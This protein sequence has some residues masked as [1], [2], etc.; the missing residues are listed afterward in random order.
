MP[1]ADDLFTE[2]AI[3]EANK[4]FF[5]DKYANSRDGD[6]IEIPKGLTNEDLEE[7]T[8]KVRKF[9]TG[10][11]R[12]TDKDK[13]DYEG[14][15]SPIVLKRYAEYLHKHR[16]QADGSYR[17]SDNWQKGIPLNVYMK[18]MFRHFMDVWHFHRLPLHDLNQEEALCAV[19]FNTIGYLFE[20]LKEKN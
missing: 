8:S 4:N 13:L 10:A 9:A 15:L 7:I 16:I 17:D 2:A 3:R 12:D 18:S 19:I 14:F 5:E 11:T 20:L 6:V 1:T